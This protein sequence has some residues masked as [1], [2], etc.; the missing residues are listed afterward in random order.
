MTPE[1]QKLLS[2]LDANYKKAAFHASRYKNLHLPRMA[3]PISSFD[4]NVIA[5]LQAK[6]KS[7]T[8]FPA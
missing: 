1:A 4:P 6:F 5:L 8:Q 7:A 2:Y 3:N